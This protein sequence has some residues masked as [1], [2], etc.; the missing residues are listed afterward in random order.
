MPLFQYTPNV[1]LGAIIVTA[2]IGLIDIPAA[3]H[4]WKIDKFDFL[5]MLTAFLGVIF[6]SVQEGLAVAV[7]LSTFRILLQIT[8][9]KTVMMG[10]IPGTDIYRNLHQYKEATRIPGFLI[11]S[12]EAPINFANITY[13]N[14]RTLRWIEEE[15]E[16]NIKEHSSLRFLILDMSAVSAIDTSG[17]SLFKELKATLEKKGVEL[18]LVNPLAE[19]IEKLKKADESNTFIRADNLFLTVGEAVASLSSTM[20]SQSTTTEETHTIVPHY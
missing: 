6:I 17:I 9:P 11:L 19:V 12:I 18:V 13:L 20:K 7:G 2:V 14:D 16:D 4:I 10:N 1:V 8:R 3:C 15:E 5:V